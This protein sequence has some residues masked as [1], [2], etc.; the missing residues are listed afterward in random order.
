[1]CARDHHG[2]YRCTVRLHHSTRTILWNPHREVRV[3][4]ARIGS[5]GRTSSRPAVMHVGYRPV[6]VRTRR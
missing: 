1:M 2:T 6:M 4:M 3:R 5:G